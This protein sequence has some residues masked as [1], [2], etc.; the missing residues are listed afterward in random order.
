MAHYFLWPIA[1]EEKLRMLLN[2]GIVDLGW[3]TPGYGVMGEG[4][5]AYFCLPGGRYIACATLA[6]S[7]RYVENPLSQKYHSA[8]DL[9]DIKYIEPP[10]ITGRSPRSLI[11]LPGPIMGL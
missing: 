9:K 10:L 4:D 1:D 6:G 2:K 5:R 11:I 3:R 8:V 7:P